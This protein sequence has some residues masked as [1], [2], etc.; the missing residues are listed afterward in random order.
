[1]EMVGIY[2]LQFEH[3]DQISVIIICKILPPMWT[4]IGYPVMTLQEGSLMVH[5][6]DYVAVWEIQSS[7]HKTFW[8]LFW[9][10]CLTVSACGM[11]VLVRW[12]WNTLCQQL[13]FFHAQFKAMLWFGGGI[14]RD[15]SCHWINTLA[16]RQCHSTDLSCI[17]IFSH[18]I[19][20]THTL[21]TWWCFL[22]DFLISLSF[23]THGKFSRTSEGKCLDDQSPEAHC[24]FFC[25][26]L[27]FFNYLSQPSL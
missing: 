1:M 8:L 20:K 22:S 21:L 3:N 9:N 26:S 17:Q 5:T 18:V 19:V 25:H 16:F 6:L 27:L 23:S 13:P 4:W 2:F 24:T 15:F 14:Q 11:Q 12:V 7:K 10:T